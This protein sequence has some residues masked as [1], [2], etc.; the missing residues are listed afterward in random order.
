MTVSLD[1]NEITTVTAMAS[2]EFLVGVNSS[3][4]NEKITIANLH[5]NQFGDAEADIDLG[6]NKLL[7]VKTGTAEQMV[8][9]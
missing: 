6:N 5:L 2:S 9:T 7:D 8:L 1:L 4:S 3:A